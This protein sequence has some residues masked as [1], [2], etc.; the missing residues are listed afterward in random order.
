MARLVTFSLESGSSFVAE[1][2]DPIQ[3]AK[4]MRGGSPIEGLVET[5]NK[6]F[7]VAVDTVKHAAETVVDRFR[8]LSRPPEELTLELGIKL[9]AEA[10]AVIAKTSTDAN[11]KVTMSWKRPSTA[12]E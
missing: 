7:E 1:V 6:T 5:T 3:G 4:T 9:S 8:S 2:D 12:A 10:G 11:I